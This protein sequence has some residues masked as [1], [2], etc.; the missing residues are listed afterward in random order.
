MTTSPRVG[1]VGARRARQ[2][3]GPFVARDL[4]AAGAVVPCFLATG[5]ATCE[6]ARRA[7]REA[8]GIEARGYTELGAMLEG[9]SLDALAI[10]SPAETH[11]RYLAAAAERGLHALCEK[12]LC[13][14]APDPS[15]RAARVVA[16]FAERGLLLMENCQWPFALPAFEALH[17]GALSRPPSRFEM[18]LEPVSRGLQSL[19]D[20]LPHPISLLQTLL[21]GASRVSEIAFSTRDPAAAQ[22][23][24]R[25]RYET[26]A[27]ACDAEVRLASGAGWPRRAELALDGRRA[28]RLV[29]PEGYRLSFADAG[30][31]VPLPDPLTRLVAA[32]VDALRSGSRTRTEPIL[33]RMQVLSAIA[34]AYASE[35]TR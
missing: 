12:P 33:Q 2:G 21:P 23:T 17:P 34:A 26:E 15:E 28:R 14:G 11:E 24:V 27:A 32:F 3:L 25:L 8:A 35:E 5:A 22:L 9:E 10:L 18:L 13:W 30:R 29:S 7:L 1:I 4:V 19:V 6:E 31:S 20:S 16:G